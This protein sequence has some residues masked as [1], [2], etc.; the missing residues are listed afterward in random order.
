MK[1]ILCL[2]SLL[3]ALG[4]CAQELSLHIPLSNKSLD[5]G[6]QLISLDD[7][8]LLL[9]QNYCHPAPSDT[10][11]LGLLRLDKEG[12][13]LWSQE[14]TSGPDSDLFA[15]ART[16]VLYNDTIYVAHRVQK[17]T[18]REMRFMAFDFHDGSFLYHQDIEIEYTN[19]L[20]PYGLR[21]RD[22]KLLLF[23]RVRLDGVNSVFLL[24]VN[25]QFEVLNEQRVAG[26]STIVWLDFSFKKHG[27]AVVATLEWPGQNVPRLK[28]IHLDDDYSVVHQNELFWTPDL[29]GAV[30]V[31]ETADG[32]FLLMWPKDNFLLWEPTFSWPYTITK[33]DSLGNPIWENV[34]V[35]KQLQSPINLKE[36]E[37]GNILGVGLNDYYYEEDLPPYTRGGW[38]FL[39]DGQTGELLWDRAIMD[40]RNTLVGWFYDGVEID[41][42]FALCGIIDTWNPDSIPYLNDPEVW[43]LTLDQNGCWNGNC[44]YSIVI[45]GDT[46]SESRYKPTSTAEAEPEEPSI[47]LFPNPARD[48]VHIQCAAEDLHLNRRV[49]ITDSNGKDLMLMELNAPQSS[50]SLS[51]F[52][53]GA[54]YVSYLVDGQ[55]RSTQTLLIQ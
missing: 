11:C 21:E 16:M 43:F 47:K 1:L 17:P 30:G 37:I 35:S 48:V 29:S 6:N 40:E 46:T 8:Y 13:V 44:E 52:P 34:L 53:P 19:A 31:R 22:G 41:E 45:T 49:R 3:L 14:E 5:Q 9:V 26:P 12:N 2:G 39:L 51:H 28:F 55:L 25:R 33:V 42:G 15:G 10:E 36:T 20:I 4:L 18:Q 24:E 50:I 27:G 23:G 32:N 54:Y 38:C 7:G